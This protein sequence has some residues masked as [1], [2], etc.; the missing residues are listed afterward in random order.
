MELSG[1]NNLKGMKGL[2]KYMKWVLFKGVMADFIHFYQN[3]LTLCL[4]EEIA[5]NG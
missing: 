3:F 4:K 5:E 1:I 2:V